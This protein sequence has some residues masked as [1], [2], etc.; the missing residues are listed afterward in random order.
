[1]KSHASQ[2]TAHGTTKKKSSDDATD[3]ATF[4]TATMEMVPVAPM[5]PALAVSQASTPSPTVTKEGN[6]FSANSI[7]AGGQFF[8]SIA[9]FPDG[10]YV[11]SWTDTSY[12]DGEENAG[13]RAQIF[14]KNNNKVGKEFRVNTTVAGG[15]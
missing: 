11:I 5:A 14:D 2:P 6:E 12:T 7:T 4:D 13:I 10:S 9:T 3:M 1:M 8:S 15:Q